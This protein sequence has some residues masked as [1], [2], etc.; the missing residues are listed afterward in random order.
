M[1]RARQ[2]GSRARRS[3]RIGAGASLLH[4][5]RFKQSKNCAHAALAQLYYEGS[6]RYHRLMANP[7]ETTAAQLLAYPGVRRVPSPRLELFD[8]PGFLSP[9]LCTALVALI[10]RNRRPSEIADANGDSYF[11]TSETCDLEA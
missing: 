11:R 8:R 9:E 1:P 6:R 3:S 10:D 2:I 5:A 7:G 4:R